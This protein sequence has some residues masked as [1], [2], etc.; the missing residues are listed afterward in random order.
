MVA[1]IVHTTLKFSGFSVDFYEAIIQFLPKLTPV[2]KVRRNGAYQTELPPIALI[3]YQ[4]IFY[5][6][7]LS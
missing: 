6:E 3:F 4:N 1:I 5:R 7:D 2:H